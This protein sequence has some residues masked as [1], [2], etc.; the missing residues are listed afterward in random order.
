MAGKDS[1]VYH[2]PDGYGKDK[3][4]TQV[5]TNSLVALAHRDIRPNAQA[6]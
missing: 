5:G 1:Q 3:T 6:K 4:R 2:T